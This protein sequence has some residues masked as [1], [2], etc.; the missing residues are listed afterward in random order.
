MEICLKL[1][2]EVRAVDRDVGVPSMHMAV[3]VLRGKVVVQAPV[4]RVQEDRV[5]TRR[6]AKCASWVR[7]GIRRQ[8]EG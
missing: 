8:K 1:Q 6:M 7:E 5:R 3:G 2:R 4:C